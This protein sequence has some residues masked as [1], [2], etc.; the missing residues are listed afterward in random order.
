MSGQYSSNQS[1]IYPKAIC[2]TDIS[3]RKQAEREREQ[4]DRLLQE[5]IAAQD[6]T[7]EERLQRLLQ[8]GCESFELEIGFI[9][10]IVHHRLQP[11]TMYFTSNLQTTWGLTDSKN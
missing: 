5:A 1:I 11:Q 4:R 7:L 2:I 6:V 8:I 3:D 9:S 10:K